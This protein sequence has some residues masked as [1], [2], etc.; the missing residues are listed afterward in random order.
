MPRSLTLLT[1]LVVL[2]GCQSAYLSDGRP[3]ESSPLYE[4]PLGSKVV[5]ERE[6]TVPAYRQDVFLQDGKVFD[7][8]TVNKWRPYCA[9]SLHAQAKQARV[10]QPDSF[11][12][13]KVSRQLLFQLAGR[14]LQ[15]AGITS[16]SDGFQTWRVQAAV[17]ELSSGRQPDV[18]KLTCAAWGLPQ[19][20][21]YVTL[22]AIRGAL[23]EVVSLQLAG[24]AAPGTRT[25]PR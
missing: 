22:A 17:M 6:L 8:A 5:L 16:G 7:F 9:L 12:V 25:A 2:A 20:A 13:R 3:N 14:P 23:G 24:G 15:I 21:S 18:V 19:D 1:L 10:M 11:V 4:V